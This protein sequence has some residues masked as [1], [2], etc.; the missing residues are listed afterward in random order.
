MKYVGFV[1]I[2]FITNSQFLK[3]LNKRTIHKLNNNL[4]KGLDACYIGEMVVINLPR[5][6]ISHR[7]VN[8]LVIKFQK[9]KSKRNTHYL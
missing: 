6:N 4:R 3:Y 9:V 7:L 8:L 2:V 5:L 1:F